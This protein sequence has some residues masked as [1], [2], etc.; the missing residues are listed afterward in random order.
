[1]KGLL[2]YFVLFNYPSNYQIHNNFCCW[3]MLCSAQS[4]HMHAISGHMHRI[5]RGNIGCGIDG[6]SGQL[7]CVSCVA[8]A[9]ISGDSNAFS[10][11]IGV[12]EHLGQ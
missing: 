9:S 1:M 10:V 2:F 3:I 7:Q 6:H 11:I 4:R 8:D 5:L 12:G